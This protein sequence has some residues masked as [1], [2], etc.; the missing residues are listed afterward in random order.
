LELGSIA[1]K[2]FSRN[3][4]REANVAEAARWPQRF[5]VV[6]RRTPYTAFTTSNRS[7]RG[8]SRLAAVK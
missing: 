8:R 3:D 6:L 1:L 2:P 4:V 5:L 7:T